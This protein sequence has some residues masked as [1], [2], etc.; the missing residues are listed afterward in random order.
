MP[1]MSR[2]ITSLKIL[3]ERKRLSQRELGESAG[4]GSGALS[5]I[6]SGRTDPRISTVE[7][8]LNALGV[9][10]CEAE[11][12]VAEKPGDEYE[13]PAYPAQDVAEGGSVEFLGQLLTRPEFERRMDNAFDRL[14]ERWVESQGGMEKVAERRPAETAKVGGDE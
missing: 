8:L 4:I 9:D 13:E 14:L 10:F 5:R 11:G 2:I 3:R 6:E 12:A 1:S 7:K